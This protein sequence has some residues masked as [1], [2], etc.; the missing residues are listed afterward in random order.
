MV[1]P[2]L[3]ELT[4]LSLLAACSAPAPD[5]PAGP[6]DVVLRG[7]AIVDGSGGEPFV[8][9]VGVRGDEIAAIGDLRAATAKRV[10]EARGLVVAPGFVD[11]HTHI[12]AALAR[13]PAAENFV[14]MGVTTVVSGNCGSSESDVAAHLAAAEASRPALNYGTLIGAGTVRLQVLGLKRR[15]PTEAEL[16]RMCDLVRTAMHSGAFGM[17]SG[18]VY[19]PGCYAHVDELAALA[20]EVAAAG[21]VYASHVR[22]EEERGAAAL[23]EA[24]AVGSRAGCAVH[25]SHLKA[26]GKPQWGDAERRVRQLEQARA[27]GLRVTADQYVYTAS[28]TSLD[29][30]FP[31]AELEIG[32]AAFAAK[33]RDDGAFRKRMAE[34][35]HA[36]MRRAGFGDLSYA[37]VANAAGHPELAGKSLRECAKLLLGAEDQDAQAEAALRIWCDANGA[38]VQMVYH[39]MCEA[40]VARILAADWIAI[41]SDAGIRGDDGKPHPRGSGNN[42]RVLSEYVR[43][44][45]VLSLPLAVRKMSALPAETF[46]ITGR[47]SLRVGAFADLV[48]FDPATVRDLAT[49]DEP[50]RGPQGFAYVFVNGVAVVD[51]DEPTGARPGAVL[52][53]TGSVPGATR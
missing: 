42:A 40:D 47:G 29:V 41:A 4:L 19:V 27:K 44:R 10:V 11:V 38:R 24:I 32:R 9:D 14:R 15:A 37:H 46:G 25:V 12:D 18:L 39:K 43:E 50:T 23:D 45:R 17:S 33:L 30:L 21:G 16:A 22:N 28:S 52:R 35:L 7:G 53:H 31:E 8:A 2:V 34:A 48:V 20:K 5:L 13:R 49:Y 26:S 51:H 1:R 6:F 36:T 3:R